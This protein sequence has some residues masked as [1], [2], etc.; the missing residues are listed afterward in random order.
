[1][2]EQ[3]TYIASRTSGYGDNEITTSCAV[4]GEKERTSRQCGLGQVVW[5]PI[6]LRTH[7]LVQGSSD[8]VLVLSTLPVQADDA[9]PGRGLCHVA[10]ALRWPREPGAIGVPELW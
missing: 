8:H 5:R 3:R 7:L 6:S 2:L 9:L 4:Y 10:Y 1:V